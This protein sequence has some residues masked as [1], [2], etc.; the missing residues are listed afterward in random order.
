MK[1]WVG[2]ELSTDCG[3]TLLSMNDDNKS[4]A[5]HILTTKWGAL[6]DASAF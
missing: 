4:Q 2:K 5:N 6:L 3:P 1:Q